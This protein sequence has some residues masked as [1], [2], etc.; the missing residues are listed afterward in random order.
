MNG[1]PLIT[2][3]MISFETVTTIN[4][5]VMPYNLQ[6]KTQDEIEL[7]V[8]NQQELNLNA[9]DILDKNINLKLTE[10]DINVNKSDSEDINIKE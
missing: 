1:I 3:G 9:S 4:R 10:K 2:K 8:K 7:Q 6:I 5:Y